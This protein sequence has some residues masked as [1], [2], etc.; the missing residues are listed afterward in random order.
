MSEFDVEFPLKFNN[1]SLV[2]F[3]WTLIAKS[4]EPTRLRKQVH[5]YSRDI[6]GELL[7]GFA[8]TP[9]VKQRDRRLKRK[10]RNIGVV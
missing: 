5:S 10:G 9:K 8:I 7:P 3:G 4:L 1:N 2:L 6:Y